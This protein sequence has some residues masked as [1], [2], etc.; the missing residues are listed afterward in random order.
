MNATTN[1]SK[2]KVN[3]GFTLVEMLVVIG[4][5]GSLAAISFPVYRGIQKKVE[6][7]Q[8]EMQLT[9]L[10]RSVDYFVDEYNY[11]PS[12]GGSSAY[13]GEFLKRES[14]QVSA[15]F[16]SL[17]GIGTSSNF[18]NIPFFEC[19]DAKPSG[20]G[21]GW[22]SGLHTK[23]DGTVSFYTPWSNEILR[24]QIDSDMDGIMTYQFGIGSK[25]SNRVIIWWDQGPDA[26]WFTDDD[27]TNFDEYLPHLQ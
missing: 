11:P 23:N 10:L 19:S 7:Q 5:I 1:R 25:T 15:L 13:G 3:R 18:K 20:E 26:T 2:A 6:K 4:I 9:S 21:S 8:F 16:T 17:C 24:M 12:G 14:G 22:K 27:F